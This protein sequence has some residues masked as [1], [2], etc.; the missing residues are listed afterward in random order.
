MTASIGFCAGRRENF[1]KGGGCM[2][3][4]ARLIVEIEG[5]DAALAVAALLDEAA[6]AVAAFEIDEPNA[7][8][9]VEAY[10]KA[11]LLD[12][13]LEV[14]LR[15][16]AA[17]AGGRLLDVAEERLPERDWLRENRRAFPPVRLGRFFVHGSHWQEKP[18]PGTVA[19][20][21]DAAT[22]FG[23]GEHQSTAG[24]LLALDRLARRR[25]FCRVLDIGAGSGILAI[26]A[27][28]TLHRPVL[29]SDI[30]PEAARVARHHV[31]R[32]GLAGR[33]RVICAPGYKSRGV[34][35]RRYD[36]VFANILAR[37]LSLL[38]RDL[39]V[40]LAPGGVAILAGLLRRQEAQVLAAHRLQRL[41]LDR[42]IVIDGWSALVLRRRD[43]CR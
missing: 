15:L 38:A 24:C 39:A 32:N 22:A 12:T 11:P 42:R 28:K 31:R 6:Q 21:I 5:V 25:H 34:R 23:T 43:A 33:V 40:A 17:G 30:D 27:A 35:R 3:G 41:A 13:A 1:S 36:L 18:P 37:P 19:I 8:W 14:R 10:P 20:E 2:A 29:A 26:A 7:R 16:A 4:P 9:R